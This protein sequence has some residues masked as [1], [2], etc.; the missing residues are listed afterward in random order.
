M[1]WQN[2]FLVIAALVVTAWIAVALVLWTRNEARQRRAARSQ[3]DQD[4]P[5]S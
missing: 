4:Q 5:R 3:L 1:P 2:I